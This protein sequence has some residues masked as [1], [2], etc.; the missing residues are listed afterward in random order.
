MRE[1]AS[2]ADFVERERPKGRKDVNL[3]I[4]LLLSDEADDEDLFGNDSGLGFGVDDYD[5]TETSTRSS[6]SRK[7]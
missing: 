7:V 3:I 4:E 2:N 5:D 6:T 1:F